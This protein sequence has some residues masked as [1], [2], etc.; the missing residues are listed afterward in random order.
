VEVRIARALRTA[1][2]RAESQ[3]RAEVHAR[4]AAR[5]IVVAD[6]AGGIAGGGAAA[7]LI[8][9]SARASS[10]DPFDLG[11]WLELMARVD[12]DLF[13]QRAGETT[14]VSAMSRRTRSPRERTM[15]N[16]WLISRAPRAAR[17]WTTSRSWSPRS[18]ERSTLGDDAARL[19]RMPSSERDW[20]QWRGWPFDV[21][22]R[23]PLSLSA[24]LA[25][26]GV[27]LRRISATR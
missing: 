6:G 9:S 7:E 15:P 17:S 5:V 4:G 22:L 23:D 14:A 19:G 20:V 21:R 24:W 11:A 16:R 10:F 1:T 25:E 27:D 12:A 3:D 26:R 2:G 13:Q 18:V 8:V